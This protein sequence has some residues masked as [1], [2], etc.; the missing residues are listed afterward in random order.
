[1]IPNNQLTDNQNTYLEF[2][3]NVPVVESATEMVVRGDIEF[4]SI[5]NGRDAL[6]YTLRY[7][8]NLVILENLDTGYTVTHQVGNVASIT[9][10]FD[11]SNYP[12]LAWSNLSGVHIYYNSLLAG[13]TMVVKDI[14]G[15]VSCKL[16]LDSID[17]LTESSIYLTGDEAGLFDV[18]FSYVR[19]DNLYFCYERD[20]YSL[21]YLAGPTRGYN[22]ILNSGLTKDLR[23]QVELVHG[24]DSPFGLVPKMQCAQSI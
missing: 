8:G 7:D 11:K 13:G 3:D 4:Y 10:S 2:K 20:E 1:M 22:Y 18:I 14:P 5:I 21:E 17:E 12:V 16:G 19:D 23:F 6:E 9:A 24:V 15:A